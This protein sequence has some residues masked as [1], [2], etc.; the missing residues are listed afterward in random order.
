MSG[1]TCRCEHAGEY[2]EELHNQG[3]IYDSHPIDV[4]LLDCRVPAWVWLRR[5]FVACC[6]SSGLFGL[7]TSVTQIGSVLIEMQENVDALQKNMGT[8][9]QAKDQ[10]SSLSPAGSDAIKG[11]AESLKQLIPGMG[12]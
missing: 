11:K 2:R 4:H 12:Q 3:G 7:K 9:K 6:L 8:I 1:I 5:G 10:L